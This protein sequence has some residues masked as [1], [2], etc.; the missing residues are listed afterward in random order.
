MN[1][2]DEATARSRVE[3][4]RVARLATVDPDGRPNLVP[5]CPVLDDDTIY[6]QVDRKPKS[7][8][9]LKRVEN[10]F[11][12][13]DAVTVLIDHYEEDWERVW[14][15]R[16]RGSGRILTAGPEY[17]R[18]DRLLRLKFPQVRSDPKPPAVVAIDIT[19][20]RTWSYT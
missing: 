6:F 14:W 15:V 2:I 12:R 17:E 20:W 5:F 18:A 10:I 3:A 9:S 16:L 4:A 11:A 13:P 8:T 7:K 19:D 1:R